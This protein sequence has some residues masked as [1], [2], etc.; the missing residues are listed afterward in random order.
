MKLPFKILT[1]ALALFGGVSVSAQEGDFVSPMLGFYE[2]GVICAQESVTTRE[3]PDTVAGS[4]N[5]VEDAPPFVSEGRLVPAVLGIG[6]G[7]RAGLK[8]DLGQDGVTMT[9]THPPLTG[10]GVTQQSFI[11]SLGSKDSPGI[12][13]Y[14]F[15]YPYELMLGE[16]TMTATVGD[17]VLY[18]TKF[19]VV[20]PQTLPHLAGAC[21]YLDLLS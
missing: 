3:A 19:T 7:V 6:F 2:G 4:T 17:L 20:P 21:G 14:Q 8:D 9:V 16:W 11:T 1:N 15:D 12:T 13:F 18:E 10:S 5:V